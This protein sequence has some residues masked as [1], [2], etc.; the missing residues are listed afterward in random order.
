MKY[1]SVTPGI[2]YTDLAQPKEFFIDFMGFKVIHEEPDFCVVQRDGVK[3]CLHIDEEYSKNLAP[4]F[5]IETD[6]IQ[7]VWQE[8]LAKDPTKSRIHPRFK[9]GPE[10]RPWSAW[11]FAVGWGDHVCLVFQ[12]WTNKDQA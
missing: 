7:A 9:D 12:E 2:Q 11:E 4:L 1:Q 10:L 8:L 6:D 3:F 5:R